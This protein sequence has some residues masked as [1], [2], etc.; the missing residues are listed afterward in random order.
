MT[1]M[2]DK[3]AQLNKDF[4]F[5]TKSSHLLFTKGEGDIAIMEVQNEFASAVISLQ[6][7]HVL[8]WIPAGEKEVI[9]VSDD[10]TFAMGKSVRG[11]IPICWPWFGAHETN[12][13]FPAHGFA[14]TVLWQ[15]VNTSLLS[16]GET[17]VTFKLAPRE[18]DERL[19]KMWPWNTIAKYKI[20]IGTTLMIELSTENHSEQTITLGQALHTY[21]DINDVRETQITGLED[22]EYLDKTDHFKR[23]IQTGSIE[24]NSEVDRVY[25]NTSDDVVIN[26][27]KRKIIIQKQGSHSTVV[28][29]PWKEVADKMADLGH[30]GYLKMLCVE[31]ANAA[32]DTVNIPAGESYRLSVNYKVETA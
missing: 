31:S 30:D 6:G 5:E 14:R 26:D 3:L 27:Q 32:E 17:E 19:Q 4:S 9:W 7:A 20:T 10:A 28:W 8:S 23:K 12:Q 2:T 29:N 15:V 11:G 22:K 25:L 18:L 13:D 1:A 24:I 21:F 16:S